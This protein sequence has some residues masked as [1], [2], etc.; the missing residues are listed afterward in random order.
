MDVLEYIPFGK[1]NA[2]KRSTLRD[3]LGVTDRDMRVLIAEA[4]KEV[5]IINLQDGSGYYRPTDKEELYQ[6]IMQE[7]ARAVKI[8]RNIKV[9]TEEYNRIGG[10]MTLEDLC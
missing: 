5:P 2:I 4:R 8:I 7:N 1:E 10:Q 6:Y 3:L 9:A